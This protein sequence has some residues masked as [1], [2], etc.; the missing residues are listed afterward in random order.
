MKLNLRTVLAIT[1]TNTFAWV[2]TY[3]VTHIFVSYAFGLFVWLPFVMG[4]SVTLLLNYKN[5]ASKKTCR[6]V[7]YITLTIFCLGL[8]TFAFE[9]LIC[10]AMA[11]PLG[12]I[13]N[14]VGYR[15]GFWLKR[16]KSINANGSM[17]LLLVFILSVPTIMGFDYVSEKNEPIL[18]SVIT[19]IEIK[20]PIDS[21]W[22]NVIQFPDLGQPTEWLFNTGIAYPINARIEGKGVGAIRHCNFT[23]GTF[24]EPITV[25]NSPQLLSFNVIEQPEPMKELSP[26]DIHPNH[27]H[28]Y[29]VSVKG[30]FKLTK[31]TN[32][33]TQLEGTTWYY[34]K[35]KPAIYWYVWSD[36]IIHQ[37]H[38]RVLN[39]IKVSA[40]KT[41]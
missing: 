11:L 31:L 13:F 21:V 6:N 35:I 25:W 5:V 24:T 15:F 34:N 40:E 28:G 8:L 3:L 19:S 30:Q 26:Y 32:G 29:F 39:H 10:I 38:N 1:I 14:W 36:Y 2:F 4:I 22:K 37:I 20:A 17:K 12:L 16:K 18:H 23:T 9:G 33:N 27:L 7:S 41:L